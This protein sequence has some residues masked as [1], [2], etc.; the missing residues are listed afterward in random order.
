M[1]ENIVCFIA[2]GLFGVM[3]WSMC[4]VA[5]DADKQQE[6]VYH[7]DKKHSGLLEED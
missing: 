7:E 1:I 5:S 4:R 2:G 6:P 3:W